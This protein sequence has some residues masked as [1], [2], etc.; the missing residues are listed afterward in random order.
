MTLMS[1]KIFLNEDFTQSTAHNCSATQ[2]VSRLYGFKIHPAANR[3]Q[4][5]ADNNFKAPVMR[6]AGNQPFPVKC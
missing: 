5:Q 2:F 3:I 1:K 4:Q 6:S